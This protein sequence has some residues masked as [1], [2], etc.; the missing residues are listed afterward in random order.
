MVIVKDERMS[1]MRT[2][3]MC[4]PERFAVA[5]AINPWMDTSAPVDPELALKQWQLLRET[6]AGLG[7]TV[8]VLPAEDGLPDMVYAA[9]GAFTVDGTAFGARFR[10][11]Q[12]AAEAAAHRAFYDEHGWPYV[13]PTEINEG[14]GDFAYLPDAYGGMILAGHGFRTESVAHSHAQEA[15]GRPVLSLQ[16][17][18]PRFYHLDVALAAL[19]DERIT[20]YPGA[21]SA[22]SQRVLAQLFPDALVAD[23]A[24]ALAFGL[25]LVSD[26][27]NVVFNAEA[28][29]LAP[30]LAAAGYTPVPVELSELKKGGGSVKCCVAE[31]RPGLSPASPV[32]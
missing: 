11:P 2:Y 23:E 6:L 29:G 31:L 8:H 20:Y 13:E 18:D 30:K 5:Y 26:G 19:D 9:N 3:L 4:P 16:L 22:G 12:R 21:F 14:E 15:L 25:N 28:T 24:D 10:Y 17:V 27:R 32:R 7:H 1:R